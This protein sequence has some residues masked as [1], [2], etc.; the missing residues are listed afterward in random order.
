MLV[1]EG[2]PVDWAQSG[3][4]LLPFTSL[5]WI[6]LDLCSA[7]EL[8]QVLRFVRSLDIPTLPL[9][10]DQCLRPVAAWLLKLI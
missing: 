9:K 8:Y 5:L 7:L 1:G 10:K 2:T 6:S 4:F 3:L